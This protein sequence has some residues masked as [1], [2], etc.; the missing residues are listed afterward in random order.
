MSWLRNK[1]VPLIRDHTQM[2]NR[3]DYAGKVEQRTHLTMAYIKDLR[4]ATFHSKSKACMRL[5]S[6]GSAINVLLLLKTRGPHSGR[7][8]A[9]VRVCRI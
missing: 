3:L 9:S 2:W 5:D 6:N 8:L 7:G 1:D 4:N